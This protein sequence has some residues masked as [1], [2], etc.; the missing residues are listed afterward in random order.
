MGRS[1]AAARKKSVR[2]NR[3]EKGSS[4]R[5]ATPHIPAPPGLEAVIV[6]DGKCFRNHRKPKLIWATEAKAAKALRS[7]QAQADARGQV[8][9]D[10]SDLPR[11]GRARKIMTLATAFGIQPA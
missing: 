10:G 7:A 2:L 1:N 8:I 11:L 5:M 6:P 3:R 4:K 9:R